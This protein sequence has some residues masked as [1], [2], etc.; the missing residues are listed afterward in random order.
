MNAQMMRVWSHHLYLFLDAF[1]WIY[2]AGTAPIAIEVSMFVKEETRL[3]YLG[4][5][6]LLIPFVLAIHEPGLANEQMRQF[7]VSG[8][9]KDS[10]LGGGALLLAGFCP[11]RKRNDTNSPVYSLT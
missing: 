11:K 5:A 1:S 4:L 2:F 6:A 9:L 10:S 8:L 7:A 3:A